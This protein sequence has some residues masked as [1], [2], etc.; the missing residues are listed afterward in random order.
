MENFQLLKIMMRSKDRR[1]SK[2]R[3]MKGEEQRQRERICSIKIKQIKDFK[4]L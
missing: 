3:W 1:L 4:W 2:K